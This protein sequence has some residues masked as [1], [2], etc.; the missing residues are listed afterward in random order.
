MSNPQF[1]G[2]SPEWIAGYKSGFMTGRNS[3]NQ[4]TESQHPC[5]ECGLPFKRPAEHLKKVHGY[6][7]INNRLTAPKGSL[8][9][10]TFQ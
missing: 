8:Y 1:V 6:S 2:K 7:Y 5:P 10:R 9:E 3:L 4:S